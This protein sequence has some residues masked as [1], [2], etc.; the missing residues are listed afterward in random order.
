MVA[1][2]R[3]PEYFTG[4]PLEALV[5]LPEVQRQWRHKAA[6]GGNSSDTPEGMERG[7]LSKRTSDV[8]TEHIIEYTCEVR[9]SGEGWLKEP[10]QNMDAGSIDFLSSPERRHSFIAI[11]FMVED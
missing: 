10:A 5:S 1:C 6:N 8:E 9:A 7:T 3:A 11:V 2:C 4:R